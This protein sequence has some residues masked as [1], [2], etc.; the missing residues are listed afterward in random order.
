MEAAAP[1]GSMRPCN[2][3]KAGETKAKCFTLK[4]GFAGVPGIIL[5]FSFLLFQPLSQVKVFT[6]FGYGEGEDG[7][8]KCAKRTA[9]GVKDVHKSQKRVYAADG[10]GSSE[11][12]GNVPGMQRWEQKKWGYGKNLV[13]TFPTPTALDLIS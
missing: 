10:G 9:Q 11:G 8:E 13:V 3:R 1:S 7:L 2:P 12:A 6:V 4:N 5:L